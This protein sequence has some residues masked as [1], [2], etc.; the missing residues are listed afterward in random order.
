MT[1]KQIHAGGC[2][3]GEVRYEVSGASIWSS[4][5]YFLLL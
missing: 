3:C 1:D 2:L 4:I 5:C